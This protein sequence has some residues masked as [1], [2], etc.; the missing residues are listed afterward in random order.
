[1]CRFANGNENHSASSDSFLQTAV[2]GEVVM[3]FCSIFLLI[4]YNR[5]LWTKKAVALNP[6]YT[7]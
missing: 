3:L 2:L 1:M 5:P 7:K 6:I 4:L